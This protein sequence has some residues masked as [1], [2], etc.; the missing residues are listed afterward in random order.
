MDEANVAG[1]LKGK[2]TL[3][4]VNVCLLETPDVSILMLNRTYILVLYLS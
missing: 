2:Q 1:V 4:F 3:Q